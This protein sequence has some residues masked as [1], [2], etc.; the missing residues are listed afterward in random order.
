MMPIRLAAVFMQPSSCYVCHLCACVCFIVIQ[1]GMETPRQPADLYLSLP[2]VQACPA[3][4]PVPCDIARSGAW[5]WAFVRR[6]AQASS[7]SLAPCPRCHPVMGA[8][9]PQRPQPR[10]D[11]VEVECP[12]TR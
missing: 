8:R 10:A 6:E 5:E 11:R 7:I 1:E 12:A 9:G 4:V 2:L 3:G